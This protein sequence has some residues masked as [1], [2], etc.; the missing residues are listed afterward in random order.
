MKD[1][2]MNLNKDR[3][4]AL[5]EDV[6]GEENVSDRDAI[7]VAY[8]RDNQWPFIPPHMPDYVV[9]PET[10]EEVQKVLRI[11]NRYRIP[12]VTM[13][14][15]INVRGLCIPTYGGIILEL[16]RMKKLEIDEEMMT[17]TI[18]PGITTAKINAELKKR[19]LKAAV[20]AAPGTVAPLSNYMLRGVYHENASQG[21]DHVLTATIVLPNGEILYTGSKAFPN[22]DPYFKYFG[23]DLFGLFA[24]QP[25]TMGVITEVTTELYKLEKQEAM[26]NFFANLEDAINFT[27]DIGKLGIVSSQIMMS[28]GIAWTTMGWIKSDFSTEVY[29]DLLI[30]SPWVTLTVIEGDDDAI[31]YKKKVVKKVMDN[32][33]FIDEDVQSKFSEITYPMMKRADEVLSPE[34]QEA[35]K[36]T[37]SNPQPWLDVM[38]SYEVFSERG[39]EKNDLEDIGYE[40]PKVRDE[41]GVGDF[42]PVTPFTTADE[43]LYP[44]KIAY[45]FARGNYWA[46]AWWGPLNKSKEYWD[47]SLKLWVDCGL[48]ERDLCYVVEVTGPG[49]YVGKIGYVELDAWMDYSS[50]PA[51]RDNLV[52][53]M[54]KA[55]DMLLDIGIY[56][57][58]R[59]YRAVVK[60]TLPKLKGEYISLWK[61]LKELVDPNNIMNPGALFEE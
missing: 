1:E 61:K 25:G 50:D 16:K 40:I 30:M 21:I 59:P 23:P 18:Q 34:C 58:F 10:T 48:V 38:T 52:V 14:S 32:F 39:M 3:I 41:I 33:K 4:L 28:W 2:L 43:F 60:K 13:S 55:T 57:W 7:M 6:V 37:P 46:L 27:D 49:P 26:E 29:A 12:V 35:M 11:A 20:P 42:L 15:G 31:E 24:G 51:L 54:D 9:R 17:A 44:R 53:F 45:W 36:I 56:A 47:K 22:I 19:G 5:L 8:S